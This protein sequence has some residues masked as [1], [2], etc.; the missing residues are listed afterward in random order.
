METQNKI[1]KDKDFIYIQLN[2]KITAKVERNF[3]EENNLGKHRWTLV[4]LNNSNYYMGYMIQQQGYVYYHKLLFDKELKE[5]QLVLFIKRF[6]PKTD[7]YLDLTKS[8]LYIG[9][10]GDSQKH[11]TKAKNTSSKYIGVSYVKSLD[12]WRASFTYKKTRLF[13]KD[14]KT[15][16]EAAREYNNISRQ[17][18]VL[19][20][21]RDD[22]G[23][24]L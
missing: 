10:K 21:N 1:I 6:N 4:H 11:R 18:G 3:F 13:Q 8:N 17:Y 19:H 22:D 7:Q 20:L 12:R 16:I 2:K 14:F 9:E 15:E 24:I 23:N 5:N